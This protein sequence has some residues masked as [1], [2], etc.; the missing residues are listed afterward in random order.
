[1]GSTLSPPQGISLTP[2]PSEATC[3]ADSLTVPVQSPWQCSRM[4]QHLCERYETRT[5]L[6]ALPSFGCT[7]N[8]YYT[9]WQEWVALFLRLLRLTQVRKPDFPVRDN[10]VLFYCGWR[11]GGGLLFFSLFL[12]NELV[13]GFWH[14]AQ[15][16]LT[17]RKVCSKQ[18]YLSKL[19]SY[20]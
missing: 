8:T 7:N 18:M 9:H 14:P 19:F 6:A 17:T 2:T 10:E 13:I 15:G 16:H 11:G 4:H 3:S 1:M 20:N 12:I 5:P